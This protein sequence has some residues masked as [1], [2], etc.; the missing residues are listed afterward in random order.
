MDKPFSYVHRIFIDDIDK[1]IGKR[2]IQIVRFFTAKTYCQYASYFADI[3]TY[4]ET[5]A[6]N[7]VNEFAALLRLTSGE[8]YTVAE[9]LGGA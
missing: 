8:P 1:C 9:L 6:R 4:L 5:F 3:R 7:G 2:I